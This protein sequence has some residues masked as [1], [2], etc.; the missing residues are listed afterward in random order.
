M[1]PISTDKDA[2]PHTFL[3]LSGAPASPDVRLC[4]ADADIT[5]TVWSHLFRITE[6]NLGQTGQELS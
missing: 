4:A 2:A 6:I 1:V 3:N 5:L